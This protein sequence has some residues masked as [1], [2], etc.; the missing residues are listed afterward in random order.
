[1]SL[2]LYQFP[3]SHFCEKAR[4][5]LDYKELEYTT[6]NLLP[7][8]HFKITKKLG[9][10]STV[11]VLAHD[12]R[13]IQGSADI[14]SYLDNNFSTNLLT[15]VNAQHAQ[16]ALEWERY[17]DKEIGIHLRRYLYHTLLK[18]PKLLIGFF[19]QGGP[20]WAR[21]FLWLSFP[22]LKKLMRRAL[23]IN[24][25]TA[26]GSRQRML[27]ALNRLN[28]AVE[29]NNYLVGDQFTRADLT[30]AALLA[31]LFMPAGYGLDWPKELPEPLKA[32][33]EALMPQ[34]EWAREIYRKHR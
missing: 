26:A 7:G 20:I 33:V 3:F 12:G 11:P 27:A 31:P 15:P 1:M 21:P 28:K 34:L 2:T 4:W 13:H 29:G 32:D 23:D 18:H 9:Q 17:L 25:I 5:A 19:A 6:V 30:A 22:K 16:S 24:A 14:L 8:L 10:H